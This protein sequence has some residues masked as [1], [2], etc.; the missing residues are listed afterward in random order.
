MIRPHDTQHIR[1]VAKKERSLGPNSL[2]LSDFLY[3]SFSQVY[4]DQLIHIYGVGTGLVN[5]SPTYYLLPK[6][7][8]CMALLKKSPF[9][10]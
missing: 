9:F 2:L 1:L 4:N 8:F 10:P 3:A 5:H 7:P 6:N